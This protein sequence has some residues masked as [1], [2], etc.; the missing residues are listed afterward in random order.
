MI[1]HFY[2]LYTRIRSPEPAL[3]DRV[4]L[5]SLVLGPA[6]ALIGWMLQERGQA[7]GTLLSGVLPWGVAGVMVGV[8]YGL[9]DFIILGR[10]VPPQSP[11]R[12]EPECILACPCGADL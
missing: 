12:P 5:W 8:A 4:L 11:G 6:G 3:P 9:F 7:L 2:K 1:N 10:G